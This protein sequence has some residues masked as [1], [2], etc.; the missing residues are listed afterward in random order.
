M[1]AGQLG[2]DALLLGTPRAYDASGNALCNPTSATAIN[3]GPALNNQSVSIKNS[4][5]VT[6]VP[7]SG[8]TAA[9][10]VGIAV[11]L[12]ALLLSGLLGLG[13]SYGWFHIPSA[14][15]LTSKKP[16]GKLSKPRPRPPQN[17]VLQLQEEDNFVTAENG[18]M[19][20]SASVNNVEPTSMRALQVPEPFWIPQ[21]AN[22]Y[23]KQKATDALKL[24]GNQAQQNGGTLRTPANISLVLMKQLVMQANDA[25][26][27]PRVMFRRAATADLVDSEVQQRL[28]FTNAVVRSPGSC[29]QSQEY[30]DLLSAT[31]PARAATEVPW[32]QRQRSQTP[33]EILLGRPSSASVPRADLLDSRHAKA[34]GRGQRWRLNAGPNIKDA[35]SEKG[36][37]STLAKI[38]AN[39]SAD[40]VM[41]SPSAPPAV[42]AAGDDSVRSWMTV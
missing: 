5:T 9:T 29:E 21:Q 17:R 39:V 6:S 32:P 14:F 1:L 10:A 23:E 36:E 30:G 35:K 15:S 8:V 18:A 22:F 2:T 38:Q 13:Y 42:A 16:G 40:I 7:T 3:C 34:R 41:I 37:G 19:Q 28:H 31:V 4:D 12:T 25:A 33:L 20:S 11:A 24:D 26:S 27:A